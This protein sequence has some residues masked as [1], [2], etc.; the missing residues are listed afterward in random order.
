MPEPIRNWAGN[1]EFRPA[2]CHRPGS[3]EELRRVVAGAE[4]VRVLGTGHSFNLLADTPGDL[5]RLDALPTEVRID[6]EA[7]TA[8]VSAGVRLADLAS[9]L[10]AEGFA[11]PALPSLPHISLAGACA[12]GTH[13]SGDRNQGLAALVRAMRIVGPDGDV[14]DLDRA[15]S[16]D[17]AGTVVA[18]GALGVVTHMTVDIV[19]AFTVAQH[20]YED[21]PLSE[22]ITR[23]DEV[24]SAG[25]SVSGFTD[26]AGT[27]AVWLKL[28]D[29]GVAAGPGA[30]RPDPDW[31]GGRLAEH[32]SHPIPGLSAENCTEQLGVPGPWHERLPHFRP[33]FTPSSGAELQSEFFL[34][35]SRAAEALALVRDLGPSIAPVVQ[36]SEIRTVAADDLWLSPSYGRDSVAIHFTWS[37][38]LA[39][40]SPVLAAVESALLPL[41]ARPHWGKVFQIEPAAALATYEKAV[42]FRYL[43]DRRDPRGKFRNDV[44]RSLF[45]LSA[46]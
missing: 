10:H 44:V 30:S 31:L 34:P 28:A 1:V 23:F 13:G 2:R 37:P 16:P 45:P 32:A 21:V 9:R 18:L 33:G 4:A 36:I 6:P 12:T 11:L 27:A 3:L 8:T 39:A 25:Y 41:G 5:I 14:V 19:P 22:L 17:F 38:D 42:D 35:R 26:W 29:P 15:T 24:F 20:V 46:D 7:R 43:L 40:V